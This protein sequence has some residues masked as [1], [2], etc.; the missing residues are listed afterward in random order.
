MQNKG[1]SQESMLLRRH[2]LNHNVDEII[3]KIKDSNLE[4]PVGVIVDTTDNIG[5][6]LTYAI[7]ESIGVPKHEIPETLVKYTKNDAT[8]T[9]LC[10]TD[11]EAA[12]K[13]LHL[14]SETAIENLGKPIPKG[15]A[16]VVV[17]GGGGN[18]YALVPI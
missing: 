9:F 17:V 5:K 12:K 7:M 13:V 15:R 3:R 10:V 1:F 4:A 16:M 8:P 18:S 2:L 6:Q 14:T 11:L